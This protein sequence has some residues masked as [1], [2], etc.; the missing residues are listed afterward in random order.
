MISH[1]FDNYYSNVELMA[2]K[3]WQI[4]WKLYVHQWRIHSNIS[5]ES[6]GPRGRDRTVV[7]FTTTY[8]I[9]AY[10]HKHF[11]I[12]HQSIKLDNFGIFFNKCSLRHCRPLLQKNVGRGSP[13]N[14][15]YHNCCKKTDM[16]M[17]GSVNCRNV[18]HVKIYK[19][20]PTVKNVR[21]L[22]RVIPLEM[23]FLLTHYNIS[24]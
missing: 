14:V 3:T 17:R 9:S 1:D 15:S 20:F 16:S 7:G 4:K 2:A 6:W 11:E 18:Q 10:H 5:K 21:Q 19:T 13:F 8:A 22:W 23:H 24:Q 12:P